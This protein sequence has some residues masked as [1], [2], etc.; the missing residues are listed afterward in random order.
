MTK[1][2]NPLD[3][4]RAAPRCGAYA[5]RTGQP[6]QAPAMRNGRCRMHGGKGGRP[7]TH[8]RYTAAAIAERRRLRELLHR[9]RELIVG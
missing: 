5:R 8:G 9:L 6:C 4:A 2:G 1:S 3:L 7:P